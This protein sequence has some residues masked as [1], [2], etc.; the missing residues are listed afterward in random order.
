MYFYILLWS[1][2]T[3][4]CWENI[5]YNCFS[6]CFCEVVFPSTAEK[7]LSK[8]VFLCASLLWFYQILL[9]KHCFC[10]VV[11]LKTVEKTLRQ[12]HNDQLW[13][14]IFRN[15]S[16]KVR[17]VQQNKQ[18]H[19]KDQYSTRSKNRIT[20]ILGLQMF[21]FPIGQRST[22]PGATSWYLE[23]AHSKST[24]QNRINKL[25]SYRQRQRPKTQAAA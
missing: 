6:V 7:T 20:I 2:V 22:L 21:F 11:L 14:L 4:Y 25:N 18:D 9:R 16:L 15:C 13:L 23:I 17:S 19:L 10:E 3:K 5:A 1:G 8:I 12:H 24:L